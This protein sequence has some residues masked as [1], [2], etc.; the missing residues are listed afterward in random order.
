MKFNNDQVKSNAKVV[1]TAALK[2]AV[3]VVA[4]LASNFAMAQEYADVDTKVCGFL[5]KTNNI[6]NMASIVV[7]TIAVVFAGYQIAFAHKRVAEVAPVLLGGVLIGAAG[8]LAKM[9]IGDT[10]QKQCTATA[11]IDMIQHVLHYA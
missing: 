2:A 8:Q 11:A 3:F 7:V 5:G 10:G 1:G 4:L 6:L 9:L